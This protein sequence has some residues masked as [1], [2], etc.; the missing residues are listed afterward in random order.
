MI[1]WALRSAASR[2]LSQDRSWPRS[3]RRR[4]SLPVP[5]VAARTAVYMAL[6]LCGSLAAL[7]CGLM[8]ELTDFYIYDCHY[9][10]YDDAAASESVRHGWLPRDLPS[11]AVDIH[12]RHSCDTDEVWAAFRY[13]PHAAD[14]FTDGWMKI[15][16]GDLARPSDPNW[17]PYEEEITW[18][19][20]EFDEAGLTVYS[21]PSSRRE[22]L[23]LDQEAGTGYYWARAS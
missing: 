5:S 7:G 3:V 19:P 9:A 4:M 16:V 11:S 18:W 2:M 13:D 6:V 8:K 1:V 10:T 15:D 17:F 14:D 22:F 21:R 23:A 12:E 20:G